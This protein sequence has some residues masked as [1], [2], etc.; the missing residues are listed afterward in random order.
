ML[1]EISGTR[2]DACETEEKSLLLW[3][4]CLD[5]ARGKQNAVNAQVLGSN[6]A[7]PLLQTPVARRIDADNMRL[8]ILFVDDVEKDDTL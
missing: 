2:F 6:A 1:L 4:P 8:L 3:R 7:L 5:E